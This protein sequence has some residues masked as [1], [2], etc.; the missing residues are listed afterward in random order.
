MAHVEDSRASPPIVDPGD[1]DRS[2][3]QTATFPLE[4]FEQADCIMAADVTQNIQGYIKERGMRREDISR[5]VQVLSSNYQGYAQMANLVQSWL[6]IAGDADDDIRQHMQRYIKQHIKDSFDPDK[7]AALFEQPNSSKWLGELIQH[8]EWRALVYDL[9]ADHP[10]SLM[11]NYVIKLIADAG[12]RDEIADIASIAN[13]LSVFSSV[14]TDFLVAVVADPSVY[15]RHLPKVRT[16]A[17]AS[18]HTFTYCQM[19]LHASM[20]ATGIHGHGA[21]VRRLAQDIHQGSLP[22]RSGAV[23]VEQLLNVAGAAAVA[24]PATSAPPHPQRTA[25]MV[26]EVARAIAAM[27]ETHECGHHLR[28][29]HDRYASD[30][31]PPVLLLHYPGLVDLLADR[32]YAPSHM[33]RT[34]LSDAQLSSHAFTLAYAVAVPMT[35]S[36]GGDAGARDSRTQQVLE[37]TAEGLSS[38]YRALCTVMQHGGGATA[39]TWSEFTVLQRY[40]DVPIVCRGLLHWL[41]SVMVSPSSDEFFLPFAS[42]NLPPHFALLDEIGAQ[43]VLLH[44]IVFRVLTSLFEFRYALDATIAVKLKR[45]IME[46]IVFLFAQGHV[47][48]VLDYVAQLP[49]SVDVSL[50]IYFIEHVLAIVAPPFSP[51]FFHKVV[52][53]ILAREDVKTAITSSPKHK[54]TKVLVNDFLSIG[55]RTLT[56]D[57]GKARADIVDNVTL[58]VE[59]VRLDYTFE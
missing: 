36:G 59:D 42:G 10:A 18:L 32:L 21:V 12:H 8:K 28:T 54:N 45:H 16:L 11:L 30:H 29:L 1:D 57:T 40:L 33:S 20:D 14:L 13:A 9:A 58:A 15:A 43:H 56:D 55:A 5:L 7:A 35:A 4:L 23:N 24:V 17:C 2:P 38:T 25:T 34:R 50:V 48:P 52:M 31:P 3:Q 22:T 51:E 19:L 41:Q 44:P 26:A 6:T 27:M 47:L 49:K 39:M 46:R 53:D 37:H